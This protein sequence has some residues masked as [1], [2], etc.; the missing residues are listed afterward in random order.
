MSDLAESQPGSP[1]SDHHS[2]PAIPNATYR[3]QF[4]ADFTF[5][6][7]LAIVE[8]LRDLGVSDCYASPILKARA[9]STHGYDVS[10]PTAINPLLGGEEGFLAW[11]AA[12]RDHAMG[13]VVDLVPNHMG[14]GERSNQWWMDVLENGPGSTYADYFDIDWTPVKRELENKV[15]LPILG[16]Q[17]GVVLEAGQLRLI[18][19]EQALLL[20]VYG[21]PLPI[22]PRTYEQVLSPMLERL[23]ERLGAEDSNVYE[24][25]S[26]LTAISYLPPRT[27]RDQE[28]LTERNRE[29]EIIKRR[30]AALLEG[31][32]TAQAALD[33]TIALFNGT[34]GDPRSF[35]RLDTLIEAQPYRLAFWRVA[36]E[37]INYR[38]FF[39]INDL[40]AIRIELPQV[41]HDTHELTL[42]LVAAGHISG[43]RI[44]HPDGLWNPAVYFRQLQE[45]ALRQRLAAAH[46]AEELE[47]VA[48]A[49]MDD[50]CQDNWT[51]T[52]GGSPASWPLYVVAE[53]IL[54]ETEPLPRDW[55]VHGTTGYDFLVQVNGLFVDAR[56]ARAFDRIYA[57]FT[58]SDTRFPALV[59]SSKKMIMLISLSSEINALS[60]QLN[61]LSEKNRHYRDFTLN[62]LTFAMRE[63]I[64]AMSIYRT[65]ITNTA[66]VSE[67]DQRYIA[68]AVR[69]AKRRNPRTAHSIFDFIRDTLL[70]R[71]IDDF[72]AQDRG[73]ML[74][75]IMKFQ[76][77]TGPVM[78][79]SVED[80]AF[81]IYNR[82]V[83]LNEVGGHPDHFGTSV[84]EF[85]RQ[86]SERARIWP[87]AMLATSTH[88]TK[89]SEDVR[90]RLNVLSEMPE[91]WREALRRWSR[92]NQAKKRQDDGVALPDR[93]DEYLFYQTLLGIW[94]LEPL[95]PVTLAQVRE[96]VADYMH[97]ATKEAK[98]HTSWINPNETYDAALREWIM[99]V[100][101][102]RSNRQFFDDFAS[103]AAPVA[104]YGQFNA[105]A[106]VLLKLTAPGVPDIYQG[107]ELWDLSL[108]DPDNR[109]PVDYESRRLLL[110]D[111]RQALAA[112]A[113]RLALI[114]EL[115]RTSNDGRIKLFTTYQALQV[116]REH[117]TLFA[118]GSYQPLEAEGARSE[119][120]CAFLRRHEQAAVVVAVPRLLVGLTGGAAHAPLGATIWG[121]TILRLPTGQPW[122]YR[123]CFTGVAH[124][125]DPAGVLNLAELFDYFP[126]ALLV[127]EAID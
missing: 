79:K 54:S 71:N 24:L 91:Q 100:L 105:L 80:T 57:R 35:D 106:Q 39:D 108:V 67:R 113:D 55:A 63:I 17:Y 26:I 15:L 70:L 25:Q 49:A 76:Q 36:S 74:A 119:H 4:N 96:R 44:D 64:A 127:R 30:I 89:R 86:T 48:S 45:S 120:V 121:D 98:V 50:L 3:L 23:S 104:C 99:A 8:Y 46:P 5:G 111:L 43:L 123:D 58:G 126:V 125:P 115:L 10:D 32:P 73:E 2:P 28:R 103:F 88:D 34:A 81:Y 13:L 33:E 20:D 56:N 14:I 37:E 95:S 59:S 21:T 12:L 85:H 77:I 90:A 47:S 41:F 83:S 22:A 102:E 53:K 107:S 52:D 18:Y 7:A 114:D 82:L 60:H 11:S 122:R 97:K 101:N 109:R 1:L 19:A 6:D 27:E 92:L 94:P 68:E 31:C 112:G 87:H 65:Y 124:T 29:K 38:R 116:R 110:A 117:R 62:S 9:S 40:A 69:E 72:S 93:N 16:D 75:F 78:A 118:H 66:S 61:R 51:R 42:R 84:R